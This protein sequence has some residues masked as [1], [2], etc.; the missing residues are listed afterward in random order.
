M[1]NCRLSHKCG[2]ASVSA[3][4][5]AIFFAVR[6]KL[7]VEIRRL[8]DC[9]LKWYTQQIHKNASNVHRSPIQRA[10]ISLVVIFSF[11][12]L[13]P[14]LLLA[15]IS[16]TEFNKFHLL[17]HSSLAPSPHCFCCAPRD[18][19]IFITRMKHIFVYFCC[20]QW[21]FVSSIA[22]SVPAEPSGLRNKLYAR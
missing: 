19:R 22:S 7:V 15:S 2:R 14:A 1:Q 5:K 13:P 17:L 6:C 20:R 16:L 3:A 21:H 9:H 12:L 8:S 11:A 4:N 18:V 10:C